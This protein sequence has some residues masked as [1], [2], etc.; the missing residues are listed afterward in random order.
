MPLHHLHTA[1]FSALWGTR[2][3]DH[4]SDVGWEKRCSAATTAPMCPSC[5]VPFCASATSSTERGW[6]KYAVIQ[7]SHDCSLIA[8]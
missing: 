1:S 5:R 6:G 2:V 3:C 7:G 8:S 4:S